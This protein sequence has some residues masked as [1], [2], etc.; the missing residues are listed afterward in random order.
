MTEPLKQ[1]ASGLYLE[2]Q[3]IGCFF[4]AA[5]HMAEIEAEKQGRTQALTLEQINKLW[6]YSKTL[7]Y[8]NEQDNVVSSVG[9]ANLA[10]KKLNA[11]GRFVEVAV[12]SEGKMNWYASVRGKD[13]KADY[14]IQKIKQAGPSVTHFINVDNAGNLLWDPHEPQIIKRG[15]FYT[16]CYRLDKE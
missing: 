9:I 5:C 13:R 10:L 1:N 4:R 2:I 3:Q 7:K 14:Y 11:S 12:F 15:V 16:I 6:E 8:I